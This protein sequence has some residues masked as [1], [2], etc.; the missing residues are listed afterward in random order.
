MFFIVDLCD[1]IA[2]F[3]SRRGKVRC[4]KESCGTRWDG[5]KNE[6]TTFSRDAKINTAG[7][8]RDAKINTANSGHCPLGPIRYACVVYFFL[9]SEGILK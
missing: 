5:S 1:S 4:A 2:Y 7:F 9:R 6:V 8:S 3:T